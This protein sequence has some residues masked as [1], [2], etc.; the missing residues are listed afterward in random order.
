[1]AD[2]ET[3]MGNLSPEKRAL[4]EKRLMEKRAAGARSQVIPRRSGQGPYPL[5]FAQELMWLLDHL[6]DTS[7]YHVP[8]ALR[9]K[10]PL[11]VEALEYALN[12]IVE[13]HDILRTNYQAVDGKPMQFIA[14]HA[15]LPL[16]RI[17]LTRLEK[18]RREQEAQRIL[19]EEGRRR[20]DFEKDLMLR[21]F[22][23]R[24]DEQEHILLLIS[25]HIASDGQSK[26]VLFRELKTHYLAHCAGKAAELPELPIQYAD[27]AVWQRDWLQGEVLDNHLNYWKRQLAGAPMLLELPTDRPRPAA[28]S[29]EGARQF[30]RCPDGMLENFKLLCRKEGATMF[31]TMLA[32]FGTLLYRWSG[33]E[34]MLIGT[35]VSG[36]SRTE[37]E[38]LIGYF[39]NSVV[40]RVNMGGDPTFRELMRRVKEVALG[41]YSHQDLPFEKL[42]VEMQPQRDLSYSPM[43]QIMFSVGEHKDLGLE[44]PGLEISPII[45]DR[46]IAKF[47][48]TFGMTELRRD[49][50]CNIE[51]CTALFEAST[52]QRL[53][54][55]FQNLLQGIIANPD[56]RISELPMLSAEDRHRAIFGWNNT[57]RDYPRDIF[58]PHLFE[59]Q[60]EKAPDAIAVIYE[61]KRLTYRDLNERAN[62]LGAFLKKHGVGPE[63]RVAVCVERSL[64]MIV[65][66][67]GVMKAGGAYVPLD[68]MYARERLPIIMQDA[69][70]PVL[71]TQR[72]M[73]DS[74]PK[75]G[76]KVIALDSDWEVIA[77]E[78]KENPRHETTW[79]TLAYVVYTSGSTGV[80]KGVMVTHGGLV[81]QYRAY[82][83]SYELLSPVGSW[84]YM[85]NFSFDVF[86]SDLTRSLCSGG[87]MVICP[88]ELLLNPAGLYGLML[89]EKVDC[90]E[91]VPAVLR[92]LTAHLQETNRRLD[93]MRIL[94]CSSDAWSMAD[95]RAT[96]QLCGSNTRLINAYGVTEATID[97]TYL[98]IESSEMLRGEGFV[99]IG[100]PFP[101]TKTY[102]LDRHMEPCPIGV[103][104]VLY[105]G[106]AG[107]ARGYLNRPELNAEKFVRD[108][109]S[110]EPGARLYNSGDAARYL[111]DGNIEFLGR[112]DNQVK[113]RGFRIELG[114]IEAVL[115]KH[116]SVKQA[117][118][119][120]REFSPGDPGLVA[121]VVPA[122]GQG[123]DI[124]TVRSFLKGK[125]PAYMLPSAFEVLDK[126]PLNAN[127]KVDRK[128]LPAPKKKS[129][130]LE[131]D[132]VA[133]RTE[134]EQN[135]AAIWSEVLNFSPVGAH[136]NFFE[137]GGHSLM[138]IQV[139]SRVRNRFEVELPLRTLF[140]NP[141]VA[142]LGAVIES[143]H[144][145]KPK[146]SPI[147][148][149]ARV[150]T[151]R[152]MA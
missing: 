4:L 37:V 25:H 5:S 141:T 76:A 78:S 19:V 20:F 53:A 58:V 116:A 35:P 50:M 128:A 92:N 81:N 74:V 106:G 17:D 70:C 67:M 85:A 73:L 147:M 60:A 23:L 46:G 65:G 12:K 80:P 98:D 24:L 95:C 31:M 63:A 7:A 112:T 97:S 83:E 40:L 99:P 44:L 113:I 145:G 62:Q 89:R 122:D 93:F 57:R 151:K 9:I 126:I 107:V 69:E 127:R 100:H 87:T 28:Q 71:L 29:F 59:K 68:A 139:I 18:E 64:E 91:F 22:L 84:L 48:M 34:D 105:I 51:Y 82:E 109:F 11:N 130:D 16:Q 43:Y 114:E 56:Q 102:V 144:N 115:S 134:I 148:P 79:D 41:A 137:L 101:N 13:R 77:K 47:D 104:G 131:R 133:P 149:V 21:A 108:P 135:L 6:I 30:L 103:P 120:A 142:E 119:V 72:S 150:R 123:I 94:V 152:T 33:Q 15:T 54:N 86:S 39:S 146:D 125:L 66:V 2:L 38:P 3:L 132:F 136:D 75:T 1:M 124:A 10:G 143:N 121:Y 96:F 49:L 14:P 90:A 8:R 111:P 27:Y 138:A 42:V 88:M 118:V 55:Y 110:G 117:V 26:A 129:A 52:M 61:D 45:I 140:E 32:A 36:R